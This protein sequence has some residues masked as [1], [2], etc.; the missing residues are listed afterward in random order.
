MSKMPQGRNFMKI[1]ETERKTRNNKGKQQSNSKSVYKTV[2]RLHS[3]SETSDKTS[4]KMSPFTQTELSKN[5]FLSSR[6]SN[7]QKKYGKM[8]DF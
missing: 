3:P 6:L 4:D 7:F 5:H 1:M 8:E 2:D